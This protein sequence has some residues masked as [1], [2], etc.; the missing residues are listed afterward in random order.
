MTSGFL[1]VRQAAGAELTARPSSNRPRGRDVRKRHVSTHNVTFRCELVIGA[2]NI[3]G[4]HGRVGDLITGS[5]ALEVGMAL[6]GMVNV[7]VLNRP[8][9]RE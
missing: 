3:L 1:V 7:Y 2:G 5:A 8:S 6:A 9:G 4:N